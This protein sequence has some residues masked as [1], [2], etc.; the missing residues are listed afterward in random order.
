MSWLFPRLFAGFLAMVAGGVIGYVLGSPVQAPV[1][2]VLFGGGLAVGALAVFDT[3][4]GVRLIAW[5]RGA[6]ETDAPRDAGFWGEIGYR[7]ERSIRARERSTLQEQARLGQFLD[8]IEASPNGVL[9][10]DVNG[11][12][13]WCNSVAASHF[14]LDPQRDRLQRLTNLVRAPAFVAYLQGGV[15]REPVS[16]PSPNGLGTLSVL[17]RDYGDGMKLVLSQDITERERADAMRRDFVANVSHEIRTPLTV[18][19]G[20]IETMNTLPLTEVERKRILTLMGQQTQRMQSLVTDLL[21]LAQLEGSP[22]PPADQWTPVARLLRQVEADARTLS[23]GRHQLTLSGETAQQIAGAEGELLSALANLA[24]NAVRY[25]PEG[26]RVDISWRVLGD[27]SG[28]FAVKDTGPGIERE[29]LPRL[30]ERFYR[31]DGSRSRDTGGT[32]LGL[33]IVKHVAQRHGGELDVQSEPGKGSTF[34][35][36]F[37][38]ARLRLP[39]A[40]ADAARGSSEAA[41]AA[42]SAR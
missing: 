12:I 22:R 17:V 36:V 42:S 24:N 13:D 26:G 33:S 10:I 9:M 30:T 7:V 6:Q 28:E 31:V 25:T 2:S 1:L 32:G 15:Y 23:Q 21:T 34:R 16:F 27:G 18:L 40:P 29:H 11:Q 8:A 37:P 14:G 5:L 39:L 41:E 38:A 20:F 3:L 19:S 35:L 4:R